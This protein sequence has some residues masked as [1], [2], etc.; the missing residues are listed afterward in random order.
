ML[1][2]LH[3]TTV[4]DGSF[5]IEGCFHD[6]FNEHAPDH[7]HHIIC[8]YRRSPTLFVPLNY[9]NFL[10]YDEVILVGGVMTN[11]EAFRHVPEK[12]SRQISEAGGAFFLNLQFGLDYFKDDCEAYFGL[13]EDQRSF[14][15]GN[16][17]GLLPTRHEKLLV[18]FH[19]PLPA[20]KKN[21]LI[22]K[23]YKL[24]PF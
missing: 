20:S 9:M 8:F 18:N 12:H 13:V 22:E 14:E 11:G 15:V 23:I 4:T 6:K 5:F 7:G 21:E 16:K 3:F 10:P 17:A 2:Y 19:K 1:D 24:G